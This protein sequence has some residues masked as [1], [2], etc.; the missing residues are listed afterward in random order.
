MVFA[1]KQTNQ[2]LIGYPY[3]IYFSYYTHSHTHTDHF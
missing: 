2:I 1:A 3:T